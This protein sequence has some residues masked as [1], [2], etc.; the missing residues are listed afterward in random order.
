MA[1]G[2]CASTVAD[3]LRVTSIVP[4]SF[5][6]VFMSVVDGQR[7]TPLLALNHRSGRTFFVSQG[8][9]LESYVI[10]EY[11][12]ATER[13]FNESI[14]AWQKKKG[15]SLLLEASDGTEVV[16]KRGRLTDWPGRRAWLISLDSGM[17][18]YSVRNRDDIV[19]AGQRIAVLDVL[20]TNVTVSLGN[21]VVV[22]PAITEEEQAHLANQTREREAR[23]QREQRE[24]E[25]LL[26]Q[27]DEYGE[28]DSQAA[29]LSPPARVVRPRRTIEVRSQP[30]LFLGTDYPYPVEFIALPPAWDADGRCVRAPTYLPTRFETRSV[31]GHVSPW[32]Y[33]SPRYGGT[34]MFGAPRGSV[35]VRYG[36]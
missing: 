36:Y 18:R 16:L 17:N 21:R 28:W 35:S 3:R 20:E 27:E 7:E 25:E 34:V 26:A 5:D 10:R 23:R 4:D 8:D 29:D 24:K 30:K 13:V 19:V 32:T 14:N 15:G 9:T 22:V 6:Y 1:H 12:P 2:V 11:V 33:G 31:H